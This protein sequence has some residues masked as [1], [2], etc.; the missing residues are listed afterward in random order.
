MNRQL[1]EM[2]MEET[3]ARSLAQKMKKERAEYVPR[4]EHIEAMKTK[5]DEFMSELKFH[6]T[7]GFGE[8]KKT[9]AAELQTLKS[10]RDDT[11]AR[12]EADRQ[13]FVKLFVE[14][15]HEVTQLRNRHNDFDEEEYVDQEGP[16]DDRLHR[17]YEAAGVGDLD[18]S[19]HGR[20]LPPAPSP[21]KPG[22]PPLG[23]DLV[24]AAHSGARRRDGTFYEPQSI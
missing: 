11:V 21:V 5:H 4:E 9:H 6:V 16:E 10:D 14:S 23:P 2:R 8:L 1:I 13:H 19:A 18:Y 22:P 3:E 7:R 15:V 12:L 24:S 17:W 20:L